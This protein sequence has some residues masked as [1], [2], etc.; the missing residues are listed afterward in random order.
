MSRIQQHLS[1]SCRRLSGAVRPCRSRSA[2]TSDSSDLRL[3]QRGLRA[4]SVCLSRSAV[5]RHVANSSCGNRHCPICQNEKAA[6]VGLP[7]AASTG[8]PAPTSWPP[9]R[10][11]KPCKRWPGVIREPL[12]DALLDEAAASLRTLE[13]DPRFVGCHVAGFFGVLH[14]WGR[15]L[16]YHPHAHFVIPGGGLSEDRTQW[17]A[18]RGDFLVHVR[19]LSAPVS[20]QAARASEGARPAGRSSARGL[21]AGLGRALQSGG[22]WTRRDEV[23]GRLRVSRRHLATPASRPMTDGR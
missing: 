2:S 5:R 7:A 8:C 13:A 15:Q 19:A 23:S 22:R 1:R 4:S 17:V 9:S 12:Y 21:A 16:Q 10:C 6:A 18:A 3:S 14:T 11:R 20:R